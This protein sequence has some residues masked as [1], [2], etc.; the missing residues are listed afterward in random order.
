MPRQRTRG[1]YTVLGH[2]VLQAGR[3]QVAIAKVLD[4]SQQSVSQ[5]LRGDT[6][7]KVSELQK[8]A[9]HFEVPVSFFFEEE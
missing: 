4:L 5:K 8:L 2:R 7:W 9:A 3:R 1:E 6:E